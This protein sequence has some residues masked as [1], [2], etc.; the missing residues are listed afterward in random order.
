MASGAAVAIVLAAGAGDR[1]GRKTNKAFL[2]VG[3]KPILTWSID[4]FESLPEIDETIV[5]AAQEEV[6]RC[7]ALRPAGSRKVRT[8][9]IGG[10]SR[11]DSEFRGLLELAPRI[12]SGAIQLVLVHDAARPFATATLVRRLLAQARRGGAALPAVPAT[13]DLVTAGPDRLVSGA[14]RHLWVAQTPQVFSARL[15]LEAHRRADADGFKGT[16]TA[17]VLERRGRPVAAV[18]G[19]FD[20]IKITTPDDLL[21]AEQVARH[22]VANPTGEP[23]LLTRAAAGA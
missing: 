10:E 23:S 11:H 15:I 5:V 4:L 7:R 21:W 18:E 20:N 13:L 9:V 2:P 19:S 12:E 14:P 17:A 8:L 22:R 3:G 6:E 1:M 16:D